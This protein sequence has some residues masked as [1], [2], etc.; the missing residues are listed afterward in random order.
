MYIPRG[1]GL[2]TFKIKLKSSSEKSTIMWFLFPGYLGFLTY[3][4]AGISGNQA[5]KD[6]R[7]AMKWVYDNIEAF[8]GNK[9]EVNCAVITMI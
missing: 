9:D 5:L 4:K 8:G 7:M 1:R 2:L 6:Q 3:D